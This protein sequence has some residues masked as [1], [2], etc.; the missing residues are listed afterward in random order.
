MRLWWLGIAI[1]VLVQP[2]TGRTTTPTTR[3]TT[4][5]PT[6]PM[7]LIRIDTAEVRRRYRMPVIRPDTS[8]LARMPVDIRRPCYWTDTLPVL[9]P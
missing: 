8:K 6:S 5:V 3:V 7:P 9:V 4:C 2:Q 1:T